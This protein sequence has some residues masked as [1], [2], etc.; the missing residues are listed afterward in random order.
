MTIKQIVS[1]V[2][3]C[4]CASCIQSREPIK[5]SVTGNDASECHDLLQAKGWYFSPVACIAPEH[6]NHDR[7][8]SSKLAKPS[9]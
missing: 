2:A 3:A 9:K 7:L 6:I 8:N 4:D 5:T 1:W